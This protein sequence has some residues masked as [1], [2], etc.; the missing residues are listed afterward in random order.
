M[1]FGI[2]ISRIAQRNLVI[3]LVYCADKTQVKIQVNHGSKADYNCYHNTFHTYCSIPNYQMCAKRE[4]TLYS[5]GKQCKKF[6]ELKF[7]TRK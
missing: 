6:A 3:F 5:I 2:Y 7:I 1:F 4:H